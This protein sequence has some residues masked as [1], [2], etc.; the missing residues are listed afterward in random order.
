MVS[1]LWLSFLSLTGIFSAVQTKFSKS[2]QVLFAAWIPNLQQR[3]T[4]S[5]ELKDGITKSQQYSQLK[6]RR[7]RKIR[8]EQTGDVNI[9]RQWLDCTFSCQRSGLL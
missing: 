2:L 8:G 7:T 3:S 6:W 4:E 9:W 1:L 5:N